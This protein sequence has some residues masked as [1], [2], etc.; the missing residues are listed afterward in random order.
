MP[1]VDLEGD[2]AEYYTLKL[3]KTL[4]VMEISANMDGDGLRVPA[5]MIRKVV[6]D[7]W[8]MYIA[9][10]IHGFL[11]NERAVGKAGAR[12]VRAVVFDEPAVE[13]SGHEGFYRGQLEKKLPGHLEF[14]NH[15]G[16]RKFVER[17]EKGKEEGKKS[18]FPWGKAKAR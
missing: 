12:A 2:D 17:T 3:P 15:D 11:F 7:H 16:F 10:Y 9:E 4:D 6:S 8:K 14:A 5:P 13:Y 1:V 18:K